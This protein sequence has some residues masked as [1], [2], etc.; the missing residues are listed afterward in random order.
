MPIQPS[1]GK[2][3]PSAL[4]AAL[5]GLPRR[6]EV[7]AIMVM[8]VVVTVA[9]VVIDNDK[10]LWRDTRRVIATTDKGKESESRDDQRECAHKRP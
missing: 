4:A 9:M 7:T 5:L 6:T 3:Y 2:A 10:R 8:P 1:P